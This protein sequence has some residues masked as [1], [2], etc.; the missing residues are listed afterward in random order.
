MWSVVGVEC[1]KLRAQFKARLVLGVCLVGPFAFAVAMQLQSS[2][3]SDTLFGRAVK[4]SGFA[5]SLVVLGFAALWAFPLLTSVVA[6]DLFSGE[7][8]YGTWKMVLTRSCSRAEVFAGKTAAAVGFSCLAS[9]LLAA[10]SV[11]AGLMI[12]GGG[13]L[14]D[15]SGV[16]LPS[17]Q[18]LYR[19]S[20]AWASILPPVLAVTAMSVLLSVVSRS[21]VVGVGIPVVLALLMQLA[22]LL[23]GPEPLR[24]LL[25]TSGFVAWHGLL[26]QPPFY[27]S[28]VHSAT[29]SAVCFGGCLAIAYWQLRQR[30]IGG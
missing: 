14:I 15:L 10:S 24:R 4:E 7:D 26:A 12:I 20:L 17:D 30:D 2:M 27:G 13:P 25:I 21:S 5:L 8:R 6:G 23:D 3:P 28:L 22:A 9:L 1:L 18:A 29:V 16:L 11:A 19:V